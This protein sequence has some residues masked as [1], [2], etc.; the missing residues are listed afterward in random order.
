VLEHLIAF[1]GHL[2]HPKVPFTESTVTNEYPVKQSLG[3]AAS[4]SHY[5]APSELH[6]VHTLLS[7]EYPSTQD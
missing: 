7:N 4:L 2:I 1:S 5:L 3:I 6:L